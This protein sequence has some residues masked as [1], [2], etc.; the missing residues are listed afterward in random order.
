[1][2]VFCT[3]ER[4]ERFG[5]VLSTLAAE[6]SCWEG[7]P[8]LVVVNQGRPDLLAHPAFA[9]LPRDF[10]SRLLVVEQGNFGGAGGF[11]RG[12][13]E[14]RGV[15]GA[16]H[17][18]LMGDDVAAEPEALRRAAALF[19][20]ALPRH[21]LGGHMLDML[22]PTHLYEAGRWWTRSGCMRSR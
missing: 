1:M 3:V 19:A 13:L 20:I 2:P 12:L 10:L 18:L 17:A 16:T 22:R 9:G 21:A 7:L 4:E 6:P 8:C 11:T 5:A 15:P 14:A